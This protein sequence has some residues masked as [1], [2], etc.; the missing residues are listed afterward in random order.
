MNQ[1]TGITS[2]AGQTFTMILTDGS[3]FTFTMVYKPRQ[4]G[5]FIS[6]LTYEA[7]QVHGMRICAGINI[8]RQFRN[9]IPFGLVCTCPDREP[10]QATDFLSGIANL[11]VMNETD[12]DEYEELLLND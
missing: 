8:L 9:Q 11:Y 1:I 3:Q 12:V 10:T 7:F 5:W 6:S 2:Y 4:F